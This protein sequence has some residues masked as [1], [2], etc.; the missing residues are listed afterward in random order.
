VPLLRTAL[1][2]LLVVAFAAAQEGKL[3]VIDLNDGT[4]VPGR[5]VEDEC[6]DDALVVRQLRGDAKRVI[7]WDQVKEEQA[8]QLRVE[9]GFEVLE[10]GPGALLMQGHEIRNKVGTVFRGLW[11][12]PKT[13]KSE[14]VYVLKTSDG[15]R[16]IRATDIQSGPNTVELSQLDV[17]TPRELYERKL[18][19]KEPTTAEDHFRL[20]EFAVTVD[21]L[22][23]AKAHFEQVLALE[24]PKYPREKIERRLVRVQRLLDQSEARDAL[25]EIQ[26]AL[27]GNRYDKAAELIQA[28]KEKYPDD[29]D[30]MRAVGELEERS[31][32]E[33]TEYFVA[34]VPGRLRDAVKDLLEKKIRD[35]KE[36]TLRAAQDFAGGEPTSEESVSR[37]AIEE[38]ATDLSITPDE[39]LSFWGQRAKRSPYKAFYR[40][41]TFIIV[42]NLEDALAKAPK[43]PKAG[44]G[45]DAPVV[46]KPAKQMTPDEWWKMKVE[47]HKYMDLRDWLFAWWVEKASMCEVLEPK[48][49]TC[50]TCFGKGYTQTMVTT[51]QGAV[52][53]FNRCQTCYM[54][55]FFRVVRFR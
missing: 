53:F 25:K 2:L 30:L 45:K 36:L 49:E 43:P 37:M 47:Q 41:G 42:D 27:F 12:N 1:A 52:P 40:D 46:P 29:E 22:E 16:R 14:G 34:R 7:P 48:D 5:I 39:V 26:R 44:K 35:D 31:A 23:E 6:T 18:A 17:Y 21:A 33:R 4:R 24:D 3:V 11:T 13:A 20:A 55:K 50:S 51:P 10:A 32:T 9:L 38:V 54:A 15:D 8:R 19:E 28:F